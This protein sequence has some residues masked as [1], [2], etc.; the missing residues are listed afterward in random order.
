MRLVLFAHIRS[1]LAGLEVLQSRSSHR[2]R[3]NSGGHGRLP[4]DRPAD[5]SS[6]SRSPREGLGDDVSVI[7]AATAGVLR[8]GADTPGLREAVEPFQMLALSSLY[9]RRMVLQ[10]VLV[11][12]IPA[13]MTLDPE[14]AEAA[15][16]QHCASMDENGDVDDVFNMATREAGRA[17]GAGNRGRE[18]VSRSATAAAGSGIGG[19]QAP[20]S[21]FA[22]A[23]ATGASFG[24]QNTGGGEPDRRRIGHAGTTHQT[25][26]SEVRRALAA[27]KAATR[28]AMRHS[29]N[30][31]ALFTYIMR[32]Y[33]AMR[34]AAGLELLRSCARKQHLLVPVLSLVLR[35][36]SLQDAGMNCQI[37]EA[38]I[39]AISHSGVDACAAAR[40]SSSHGHDGRHHQVGGTDNS[41]HSSPA[42]TR[43]RVDTSGSKSSRRGS[44]HAD[45]QAAADAD[46][47]V[48]TADALEL[49]RRAAPSSTVLPVLAASALLPFCV[50]ALHLR[51][52]RLR[53]L[54]LVEQAAGVAVHQQRVWKS[55]LLRAADRSSQGLTELAIRATSHGATGGGAAS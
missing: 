28:R 21:V 50:P 27:G 19:V 20:N 22:A 13:F 45:R 38:L 25:T 52:T 6:G 32:K 47:T 14:Y 1:V 17:E 43:L 49:A 26:A 5:G 33:L 46:E 29:P 18:S 8:A 23:D 24:T 4:R 34:P 36:V 39:L 9:T 15:L 35:L 51:G 2:N 42:S 12:V 44:A 41:G 3:G 55:W 31:P 54:A 7:A 53:L 48:S 40:D 37:A 16:L 10:R 11:D 30:A